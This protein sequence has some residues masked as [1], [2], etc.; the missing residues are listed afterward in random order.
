MTGRGRKE[1]RRRATRKVPREGSPGK[2]AEAGPAGPGERSRG[3]CRRWP[4][5]REG[6]PAGGQRSP[7]LV[8]GAVH[9]DVRRDVTLRLRMNRTQVRACRHRCGRGQ[10]RSDHAQGQDSGNDNNSTD[11]HESSMAIPDVATRV[12]RYGNLQ[13][14]I[15]RQAEVFPCGRYSCTFSRY[16]WILKYARRIAI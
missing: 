10:T 3:E 14:H 8:R 13:R 11:A 15:S 2:A 16:Y 6:Q 4:E 7:R 9:E 12:P 1:G 5:P